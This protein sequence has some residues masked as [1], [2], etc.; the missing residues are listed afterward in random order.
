MI[1]GDVTASELPHQGAAKWIQFAFE[2]A[3]G[4][5]ATI[6]MNQQT[7]F[8]ITK[9]IFIQTIDIYQYFTSPFISERK[10]MQ[11]LHM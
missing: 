11:L 5:N 4:L 8:R 1:N 6:T 10:I 7:F 9:D 2:E 3:M